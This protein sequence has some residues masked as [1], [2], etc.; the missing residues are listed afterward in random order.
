MEKSENNNYL[1]NKSIPNIH[2]NDIHKILFLEDDTII[3]G[4]KGR[5]IKILNLRNDKYQCN[6]FL[7]HLAPIYSLFIFQRRKFANFYRD[8]AHNILEFK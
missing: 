8:K 6:I 7:D 1:L 3:S 2:K 5:T 4:S